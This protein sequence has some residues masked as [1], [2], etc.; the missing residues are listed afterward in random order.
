VPFI[1][2]IIALT[3]SILTGCVDREKQIL[4][5]NNY[6]ISMRNARLVEI[7]N[8]QEQQ[9]RRYQS[10]LDEK[11]E[12]ERQFSKE[13]SVAVT[14]DSMPYLINICPASLKDARQKTLEEA[15][16]RGISVVSGHTYW[17][18]LFMSVLLTIM[19]SFVIFWVWILMVQPTKKDLAESRKKIADEQSHI[20]KIHQTFD[21]KKGELSALLEKIKSLERQIKSLEINRS[22]SENDAIAARKEYEAA[23]AEAEKMQ[24][25]LD[26]LKGF[27]K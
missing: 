23:Q 20:D 15:N 6:D 27:K 24:R 25:K 13:L 2:I 22:R 10:G 21:E 18:G 9:I 19:I 1:A 7:V 11:R 14:C 12:K 4:E 17:L 26:L 8:N 3:I 5:K 16:K